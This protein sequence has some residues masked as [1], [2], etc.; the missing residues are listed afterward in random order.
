MINAYRPVPNLRPPAAMPAMAPPAYQQAPQYPMQRPPAAPLRMQKLNWDPLG[1]LAFSIVGTPVAAA[2]G[3]ALGFCIAGPLGAARGALVGASLP[4]AFFA[5]YELIVNNPWVGTPPRTSGTMIAALAGFPLLSAVGYGI[6]TAI[7]GVAGAA[8]GTMIA[9]AIPVALV[10]GGGAI[11]RWM[12]P[13][14]FDPGPIPAPT[15]PVGPA[16]RF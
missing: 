13:P 1:E 14:T 7:A 11:A 15:G 12:N 16:Q 8:W 3:A 5:C 6:G 9:A 4:G 2:L 10:V